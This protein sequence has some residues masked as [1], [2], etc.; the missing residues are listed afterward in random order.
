MSKRLGQERPFSLTFAFFHSSSTV[1]PGCNLNAVR[2]LAW[3]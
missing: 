3:V 2:R 1:F